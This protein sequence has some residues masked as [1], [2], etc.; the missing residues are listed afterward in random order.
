VAKGAPNRTSSRVFRLKVRSPKIME[1]Q[2][3]AMSMGWGRF[4]AMIAV[5][6]IIMFFLMYQLVYSGDH[7][8]FSLTRLVSAVVMGC[9]M[10]AVML[11]FMWKMYR[12]TAVK[13]TV[14]ATAVVGVRRSSA[15][16]LS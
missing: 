8:L 6:T 2:Q 15:T 12:P 4:G 11:A 10:T 3:H 1:H 16:W 7:A 5:S 14:L 13:A 9:V